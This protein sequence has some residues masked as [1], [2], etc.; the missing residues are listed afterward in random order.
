MP[1]KTYHGRTTLLKALALAERAVT[2]A[3]AEVWLRELALDTR[4]TIERRVTELHDG[5]LYAPRYWAELIVAGVI[6]GPGGGPIY[7]ADD[8]P[9]LM[10]VRNAQ[11]AA[12]ATEILALSEARPGDLKSGG[13]A[14]DAG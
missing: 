5:S 7:T 4:I 9:A 13:P 10:Q 12:L 14:A 11:A 1:E 3:G 6:D 8:I 2:V